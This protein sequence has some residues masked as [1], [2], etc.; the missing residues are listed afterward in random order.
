M[1]ATECFADSSDDAPQKDP[2]GQALVKL[3]R[4]QTMGFLTK[5]I[6]S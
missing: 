1:M 6:Q 4:G 2:Q 3:N 5:L